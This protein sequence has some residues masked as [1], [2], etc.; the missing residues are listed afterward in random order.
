MDYESTSSH[1]HSRYVQK[2]QLTACHLILA[3]ADAAEEH[4]GAFVTFPNNGHREGSHLMQNQFH[5]LAKDET[6]S[7]NS[8]L[9][10]QIQIEQTLTVDNYP[11]YGREDHRNSRV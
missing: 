4:R 3:L 1:S 6:E 8:R 7:T 11:A 2:N 10:V 5:S 9:D